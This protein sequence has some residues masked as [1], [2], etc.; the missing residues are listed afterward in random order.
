MSILVYLRLRHFK[1]SLKSTTIGGIQMESPATTKKSVL[2][3]KAEFLLISQ[4]NTRFT[5]SMMMYASST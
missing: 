3:G 4:V 1:L 2:F 5:V